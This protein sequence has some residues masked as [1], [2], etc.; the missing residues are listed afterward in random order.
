MKR[1]K[2]H[3]N[4]KLKKFKIIFSLILIIS[5]IAIIFTDSELRPILTDYSKAKANIVINNLINQTVYNL[6]DEEGIEYNGI[7]KISRNSDNVVSSVE[8]DTV[9]VNLI[10]TNIISKVQQIISE[11]EDI[12]VSVPIGT[13][14]GSD[15]LVG[16]GPNITVKMQMG[17]A[18]FSDIVSSFTSAGIN[19]TLH[20]ITLK[21]DT[22]VYLVMPWYRSSTVVT[23]NFILAQTVIVGNVPDAYTNVIE[24]LNTDGS[25]VGD[26]F[27]YGAET[28]K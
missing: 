19:Q 18:V 22:N 4:R 9:K 14:F 16:R 11:K 10:K 23:T 12:V 17:S 20:Q 24:G 6:L 27:D 2:S 28:P 3:K 1:L 21:V 25:V 5:L 8:I 13:I 26:I 7:C 15:Y